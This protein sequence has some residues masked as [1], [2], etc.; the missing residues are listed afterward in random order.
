MLVTDAIAQKPVPPVLVLELYKALPQIKV[1][2]PKRASHLSRLVD[3]LLSPLLISERAVLLQTR[4]KL[5]QQSRIT[6]RCS[7]TR[8]NGSRRCTTSFIKRKLP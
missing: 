5:A 8:S 4:K 2:S 3:H 7:S 6:R 1:I